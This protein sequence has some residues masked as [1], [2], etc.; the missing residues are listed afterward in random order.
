MSTDNVNPEFTEK[1]SKSISDH[2]VPLGEQIFPESKLVIPCDKSDHHEDGAGNHNATTTVAC[3][4]E[5]TSF[6]QDVDDDDGRKINTN[7]R[8]YTHHNGVQQEWSKFPFCLR[9][10]ILLLTVFLLLLSTSYC[11]G[12]LLGVKLNIITECSEPKTPKQIWEHSYE[13]YLKNGGIMD[14]ESQFGQTNDACWSTKTIEINTD[15]IWLYNKYT[16]HWKGEVNAQC[17]L[18]GL[19]SLFL[20]AVI[21]YIVITFVID[22]NAMR[23]NVLYMKSSLYLENNTDKKLNTQKESVD[24]NKSSSCTKQLHHY[25]QRHFGDD[26]TGWIF[27]KIVGELPEFVLQTQAMLLYGGHYVFDPHNTNDVYLANK[28]H[29]IIVFA[30][31]L[32]LNC[33]GS[34]IVWILY[35]L[36]PRYCYGTSFNGSIFFVDK[37]S[38][39][40]YTLFPLYVI[41]VDDYNRNTNNIL[42]LLGQLHARSAVAFLAT[43]VPLSMLCVKCLMLIISARTTL[44]NESFEK[45]ALKTQVQQT[46]AGYVFCSSSTNLKALTDVQN[47]QSWVNSNPKNKIW[48]QLCIAFVSMVFIAYGVCLFVFALDHITT[49]EKYCDVLADLDSKL[50]SD[51]DATNNI[52]LSAVEMKMLTSHPELYLWDKCM[53][54]V[55]P[56][57]FDEQYK[58]QCRV[59]VVDWNR[60]QSTESQRRSHL[61]LT[62]ET[63]LN[64]TLH[65]WHMLEK[66]HTAGTIDVPQTGLDVTSSFYK[67]VHMKAFDWRDIYIT[68]VEDGIS[69]WN[70]MEYLAFVETQWITRL[71]AD[72]GQLHSIQYLYLEK[73]GLSEIGNTFCDLKQLRVLQIKYELKIDSIPHCIA[74]LRKLLAIWID[75]TSLTK[76]PLELFNLPQLLQLS[77]FN[78]NIDYDHLIDYNN[79][80]LEISFNSNTTAWL[81]WNPICDEIQLLP[82]A[83]QTVFN[84]SCEPHP[85]GLYSSWYYENNFCPPRLLGDGRCDSGCEKQNCYW[86]HG[87]CA[88]LCFAPQLTNCT[89]SKLTN[90]QCDDG[91]NNEFCSYYNLWQNA[92]E[93]NELPLHGGSHGAA[94]L[95]HCPTNYTSEI[96]YNFSADACSSTHSVYVDPNVDPSS[97]YECK[98]TFIGD[99]ACDDV[100]RSYQCLYDGGDCDEGNGCKQ[101]SN[102]YN[103]YLVWTAVVP[104]GVHKINFTYACAE[105]WPKAQLFTG[106]NPGDC[107]TILKA[108]D[109][110]HD[111]HLN[112]R[113][114]L[115]ITAYFMQSDLRSWRQINCS[116]CIDSKYYNI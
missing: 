39:L 56:F 4:V 65:R 17:V 68:D 93:P 91:C 106:H 29:F 51:I 109:Y 100:C 72:F 32:S 6:S 83:L 80:S 105:V 22:F 43:F 47:H 99:G 113:E 81:T 48:K 20:I 82:P 97:Y 74:T 55:Y 70:E 1:L 53:Y 108:E 25:Y 94:D 57:A 13:T 115:V 40:L 64:K 75:V 35:A 26:S 41:I 102:C 50:F 16:P 111:H 45:W 9:I 101:G 2:G 96:G 42:V 49:S 34:G 52:T 114:F 116:Q 38:D 31:I 77:L 86:D 71:P 8:E 18:F 67:S 78:G 46:Q 92:R 61:N 27:L 10:F 87:D 76:I 60:L 30:A 73:T 107:M 85:C 3:D 69:A 44:I 79:E 37:M 24:A 90:G 66:F 54:K 112:M 23:A 5:M 19:L 89:Y 21:L 15:T 103:V 104:P 95:F 63:I 59:F 12:Q 36:L 110:N 88:Q 84:K 28:P 7:F 58:C 98:E 62:Q 11:V 33:I 14:V